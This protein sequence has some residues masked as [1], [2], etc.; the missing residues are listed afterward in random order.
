[1]SISAVL[2]D[3]RSILKNRAP[4]PILLLWVTAVITNDGAI[5][6]SLVSIYDCIAPGNL[7]AQSTSIN[8]VPCQYSSMLVCPTCWM[9]SFLTFYQFFRKDGTD[10]CH[11][12]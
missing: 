12:R 10:P 4:I 2:W 6:F 9:T 8:N 7:S 11:K 1:M 3:D 5:V